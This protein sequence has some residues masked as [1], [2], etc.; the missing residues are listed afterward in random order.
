MFSVDVPHEAGV[1]SKS[2]SQSKS[3]LRGQADNKHIP[4]TE[5]QH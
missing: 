1:G 3:E 4:L 5:E 2:V